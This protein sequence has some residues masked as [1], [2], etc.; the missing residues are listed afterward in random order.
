MATDITG[1]L[2]DLV[3]LLAGAVLAG[4]LATRL[5]QAALV[6]QLI[7][8][9]VLGPTLFGPYFGLTGLSPDLSAIQFLATVFI[10]FLAGLEVSPEEVAGMGLP[11]FLAG[12]LIF[13]LPFLGCASVALLVLPGLPLET[14]LFLALTLSITALPVM[15]IMLTE[16][17]LTG[18]PLGRL[19]MNAALTNEIVAV[20]LFAILLKVY[21]GHTAGLLAVLEAALAVAIFLASMLAIHMGLRSLRENRHWPRWER[22]IGRLWRGREGGFAILM[23]LVLA[24]TLYS[25]ALGLTYVVGAFYAGLLITRRSAGERTHRS[26]SSLFDTMTWGFF[27]PL[28]FAFAGVEMNLRLLLPLGVTVAFVALLAAGSL[29]KIGVGGL[30]ARALGYR[31]S[32]ALAVGSLVNS[33]GAVE[34][35]MAVILLGA[36]I[37]TPEQYTLVAG[38]G[39]AT[40]LLAP[41]LAQRAWESHPETRR[42]LYLRAPRLRPAREPAPEVPGVSEPLEGGYK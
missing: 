38:V 36:G 19:L 16:F 1:F 27:L 7:A 6:G 20:A 32:D 30:A 8:G 2:I 34:L 4:E 40:T 11:T 21:T 37:F 25:Q 15:G 39:L 29:T 13:A 9:V 31:P 18:R 5:G 33:R 23:V 17:G 28:F 24:A 42:E 35:A 22:S 41:I 3:V 12:S 14:Y 26:L 10:L